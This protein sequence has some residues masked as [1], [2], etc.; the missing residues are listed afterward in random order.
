MKSVKR[1]VALLLCSILVFS[2]AGCGGKEAA[3]S[4]PASGSSD[5]SGWEWK[6]R[7][8]IVVPS[9]EGGGLDVTVRK[10]ATYLKK[11]L[12]V[13][14]TILNKADSVTSCYTYAHSA[15]NEGYMFQFTAPTTFLLDAAGMFEGFQVKDEVI[16]VSGLVLAEGIFFSRTNAPWNTPEELIAY[17]KDHPGEVSCAIDSPTGISGAIVK[18]FEE[19]AGV[20]FDWIT[21][22][23]TEGFISTIA[24][25]IDTC[26]NT[27][28]DAGAYVESGD[29]KATL[30][31]APQRNDAFPDV[32]C[33]GE[34][35]ISSTLGYYRVF[36][37]LKGCPQEAIDSFAAAVK[38]ASQD[39]EWIEWLRSSGLSDQY[40]WSADELAAHI[41]ATYEAAEG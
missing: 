21:S 30:L 35:D 41:A 9:T 6:E 40:V 26:I 29:L 2:V 20:Q 22:D 34:L 33:A 14:I 25:D 38:R 15:E 1:I 32:P 11:E 3:T 39:P 8:E 27:W 28:S 13:D 12:G 31:M 19:S 7:V 37:A 5:N 18:E 17:M 4:A 23:P 16:P 10:F 24:G 36:T